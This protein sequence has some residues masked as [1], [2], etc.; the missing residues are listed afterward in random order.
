MQPAF[1]TP[2]K[3]SL[4]A[5]DRQSLPLHRQRGENSSFKSLA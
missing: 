5:N 1:V 4:A 3:K 2:E